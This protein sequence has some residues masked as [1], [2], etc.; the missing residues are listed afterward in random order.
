MHLMKMQI[1]FL[2][3]K[4]SDLKNSD[5]FYVLKKESLIADF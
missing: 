4:K 1:S 2:R 3:K 5:L